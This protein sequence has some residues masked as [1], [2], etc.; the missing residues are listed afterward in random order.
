LAS[1]DTGDNFGLSGYSIPIQGVSTTLNR[2]PR[3]VVAD[4]DGFPSGFTLARSA[5]NGV[6]IPGGFLIGGFQDTATPTP[7]LIRGYGQ[8]PSSFAAELPG[9]PLGAPT[10]QT[11]WAAPLLLAEGQYQPGAAPSIDLGSVEILVNVFGDP[12]GVRTFAAQVCQVGVNCPGGNEPPVVDDA[13]LGMIM[14]STESPPVPTVIMHQFVA[15]DNH[16]LS[17][18]TWSLDSFM[19]TGAG[20]GALNAPTLDANGKLS[21][22]ADGS[23][24]GTY[25]ATVTATDAGGL[26]DSGMMTVFLKVPEPA[27]LALAGLALVGLVGLAR[28]R[29]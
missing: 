4:D 21:W 3:T 19:Y 27:S 14:L 8:N 18:L 29:G 24:Q 15:T 7:W 17:E 16:P 12:T 6:V 25:K 10:T 23:S 20:A 13:D 22:L 2:A 9:Q 26:S 5:N 28:R 11:S 1:V